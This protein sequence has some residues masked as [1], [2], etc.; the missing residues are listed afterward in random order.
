MPKAIA[1][2]PRD[3]RG[4]PITFTTL[5]QVDG[6]P[7]FTTIDGEKIARCAQD[8]LCGMCGNGLGDQVVFIGGPSSCGSGAFLDPPMHLEC[9]RYASQVCPHLAI[10]TA[11]YSK[12]K[13]DG[14]EGRTIA[15]FVDPDRPEKF[16][17]Y[18]TQGYRIAVYEGHPI[19]AAFP[20][21][22]VQ[23]LESA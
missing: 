18:L 8:H 3:P 19:F 14:P 21:D 7:D 2:L 4:F 16:G 23:W 15:E 13:L 20:A 22:E 9:A 6:R 12:P 5:I 10:S 1:A 11:R 17:L